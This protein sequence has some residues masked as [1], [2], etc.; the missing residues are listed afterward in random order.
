MMAGMGKVV[1]LLNRPTYGLAQVDR[2]LG[3]PGGTARRW[4]DGYE[5]AGK[6]YPPVVRESSTGDE[7][8]TGASSSRPGSSRNTARL[9]FRC[10]ACAR[11]CK[12]S[13]KS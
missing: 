13:G 8:A 12:R 5:R 7:I 1:D 4:I 6:R 2:L 10:S 3:L 11:R 9:G